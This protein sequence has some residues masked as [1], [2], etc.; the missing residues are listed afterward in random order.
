M[1]KKFKIYNTSSICVVPKNPH[2]FQKECSDLE[3]SL[4]LKSKTIATLYKYIKQLQSNI[5]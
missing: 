4:M 3:H 5:P 1:K 2:P